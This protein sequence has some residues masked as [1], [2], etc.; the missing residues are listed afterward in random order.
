MNSN[1]FRRWLKKQGCTFKTHKGG[2]GHVTVYKNGQKSV[3]PMHGSQRELGR[4]LV[5]KI[6]KDLGLE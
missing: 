3:L 2:S 4:R 6:K 1:E 5:N